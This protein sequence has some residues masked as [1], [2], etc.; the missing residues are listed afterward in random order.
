MFS[1]I[2]FASVKVQSGMEKEKRPFVPNP[3]DPGYL[4]F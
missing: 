3:A 4:C 2:P 1:N